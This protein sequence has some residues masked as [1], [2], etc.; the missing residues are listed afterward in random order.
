HG[1]LA[2][3][4]PQS[5]R[6]TE[7]YLW[8]SLGGV[9]GGLFSALVAPLIFT[10]VLEYPL[11]MVAACLLRPPVGCRERPPRLSMQATSA[12]QTE[13]HGGRSLQ[14]APGITKSSLAG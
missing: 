5:S 9:L 6:L 4:R 10:S 13:R 3:D 7:F 14:P 8:M 11:M 1:Q 12:F 2:A